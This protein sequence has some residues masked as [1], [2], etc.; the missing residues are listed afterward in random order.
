MSQPLP[1]DG[2]TWLENFS[3]LTPDYI[4]NQLNC[5]GERGYF[6]EASVTYPTDLHGKIL[7]V[8]FIYGPIRSV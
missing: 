6:I 2:F 7:C 1:V 5:D 8:Y 4:E 3:F